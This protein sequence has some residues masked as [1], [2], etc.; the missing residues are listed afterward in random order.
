MAIPFCSAARS[1]QRKSATRKAFYV[2][3]TVLPQIARVSPGTRPRC[4]APLRGNAYVGNSLPWRVDVEA[5]TMSGSMGIVAEHG[6]RRRR[7]IRSFVALNDVTKR[8]RAGGPRSSSTMD[9]GDHVS[10]VQS[11]MIAA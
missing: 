7:R 11:S 8:R 1:V 6:H 5:V 2:L 3:A 10:P 9:G 4:A